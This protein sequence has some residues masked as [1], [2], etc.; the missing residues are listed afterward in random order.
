MNS[1]IGRKRN[2][3]KERNSNPSAPLLI[4]RSFGPLW[5]LLSVCRSVV[6]SYF[7]LNV[8]KLN[9]HAPIEAL[10]SLEA[11]QED[12]KFE[13]FKKQEKVCMYENL[14]LWLYS[15][16]MCMYINVSTIIQTSLRTRFI[17]SVSK[18]L[19]ICFQV[20]SGKLSFS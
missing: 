20:H 12:K 19:P 6:L 14:K 5:P 18:I 16:N 17:S 1:L 9:F 2:G 3:K 10:L 4:Y 8:E 11:W 13:E 7:F 15:T